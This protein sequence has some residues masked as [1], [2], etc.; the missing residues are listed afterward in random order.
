MLSFE[1]EFISA[2][3]SLAGNTALALT[4]TD[5]TSGTILQ[6][7]NTSGGNSTGYAGYFENITTGKGYALYAVT[8]GKGN[9]GYAGYFVNTSTASNYGL[10]ATTSSTGTGYGV[11]GSIT[12]QGNSGFAGYFSNTDT[13]NTNANYGV[14]GITTS[15]NGTSAG[16]GGEC[17]GSNCQGVY[18]NSTSGVGVWGTSGGSS[19]NSPGVSGTDTSSANGI[20][21]EGQE[22]ATP[23]S[24]YGGY[25]YHAA[26]SGTNYALY[27]TSSTQASGYGVYSTLPQAANT[28]YAGYFSNSG[29]RAAYGVYSAIGSTGTGY[30]LAATISDAANTGYAGYF[31]NTATSGSNYA[32]YAS[33]VSVG[34][35]AGY[36]TNTATSGIAVWCSSSYSNGCGG[37][38]SW[39]NTSD[40]RL[41]D[42][43]TD[44]PPARGLDGVMK[45][46]PVLY[47]WKDTNCE[48]GE[49]IGLIAQEVEPVYPEVVGTGPDGMKNMAYGDLVVPLIKAV[50]ELKADNDNLR[51]IVEKQGAEIEALKVGAGKH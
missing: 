33:N 11:Y 15:T 51:N 29:T 13:S 36:F 18:G 10:V 23:N 24:G 19:T 26:A 45:L 35:Y 44:L 27:A 30:A 22:L 37:N 42:A 31:T 8:T 47:R 17:D 25:F 1:G 12:G 40:I 38:E 48:R 49:H 7:E 20:G 9:T 34:G 21:V 6:V 43:V 50:Q 2:W 16:V 14:Y 4:T 46:R 5:L 3:N 41:K 28:G 32:V 39:Y